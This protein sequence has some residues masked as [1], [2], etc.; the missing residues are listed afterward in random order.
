MARPGG[1]EPAC[2]PPG[3]PELARRPASSCFTTRQAGRPNLCRQTVAYITPRLANE[4]RK[5]LKRLRAHSRFLSTCCAEE[6]FLFL[7]FIVD[8]I[9]NAA[10]PLRTTIS[11]SL[12][13][14]SLSQRVDV[15]RSDCVG[16]RPLPPERLLTTVPFCSVKPGE[17]TV[18]SSLKPRRINA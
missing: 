9:S 12:R 2:V 11:I 13:R 8:S 18:G 15:M 14:S 3:P 10:F 7:S 16:G 5:R 6:Y 17:V 1:A 4:D